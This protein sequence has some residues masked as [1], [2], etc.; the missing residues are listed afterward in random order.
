M[1]TRTASD[2]DQYIAA[3]SAE[4]QP[5]LREL[6]AIIRA[7][8]PT[9]T[10]AISYGIPT[11]KLDGRMVSF[12]AAKRH[13]ALYG[14]A[15]DAAPDELRAF[16]TSKGTVQFPLT[17]PVPSELVRTLVVG[18]LVGHDAVPALNVEF[19]APLQ[20]SPNKGGWTYVVWP[21]SVRFFG[22]RGLVKVRGTIDG[23]PF[24][25]SF[26]AMG[27]GT[28]KLPVTRDLCAAIGKGVGE[29]VSVRLQERL[30][31]G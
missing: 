15:M 28:H 14:A 17:Q 22:T 12:G 2:V 16:K 19:T 11:Y 7:A 21:E 20:K 30:S 1:H 24:R 26:M 4:A 13:C 27:D 5:R 8:V 25:S 29:T 31:R 9:A 23:V 6:R 18:K 3:Q 10:E